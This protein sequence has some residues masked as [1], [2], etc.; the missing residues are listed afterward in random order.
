MTFLK[1]LDKILFV[2]FIQVFKHYEGHVNCLE[3]KASDPL[4]VFKLLSSGMKI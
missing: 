3:E 2:F 1:Q 4:V